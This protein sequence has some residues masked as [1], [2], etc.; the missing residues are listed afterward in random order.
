MAS[1][2][3]ESIPFTARHLVEMFPGGLSVFA[4]DMEKITV[5]EVKGFKSLNVKVGQ[6]IRKG[7]P[8]YTAFQSRK[9]VDFELGDDS[10][11]GEAIR[12]VTIPLFDDDHPD[13]MAGTFGIAI[14]RYTAHEL[15][16]IAGSFT[17]AL[18]E[19]SAAIQQTA[20]AAA[21]IGLVEKQLNDSIVSIGELSASIIT[22]LESIKGIADQTKM[23]GLNAAIEAARAGDAG[24]GFGVVAEEIRKLSEESKTTAEQI[25]TMT[26]NIKQQIEKAN[27]GSNTALKAAEEQGAATEEIA[28]SVEE[29]VA[30]SEQLA[31]IAQDL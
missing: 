10:P 2:F 21:D 1:K 13:Q 29:M 16:R 28:A 26:Q 15:R 6:E 7:S 8:S 17:Q 30:R 24:R 25:R 20:T 31:Q 27:Q 22:V 18:G 5:A 14:P 19:I 23:L 3:L 12:V 4:T 9:L 11:Y